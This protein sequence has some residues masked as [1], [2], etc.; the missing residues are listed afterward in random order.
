MNSRF[1]IVLPILFALMLAIGIFIGSKLN[2]SAPAVRFLHSEKKSSDKLNSVLNFIE[3]EYVDTVK[4]DVLVEKAIGDLLQNLDPHSV[5]MT[6]KDV[7][8]MREPMEG[9][10]EGIGIEFSIIKDTIRV[11]SAIPGGPSEALGIKAG[12]KIVKIEGKN[13]A[14]VKIK[15]KDV[16][17]K[18]RGKGGTKVTVSILRGHS[19]KLIDYT[20]TRG[21]IPIYSVDAGYMLNMVTGYIKVSRF[22]ETTHKEFLD[23]ASKLRAEGMKNMILDLRGNGGGLL[24]TAINIC[25]EFLEKGKVIVYTKGKSHPKETIKATDK[26]ILSDTKL[27]V[28]IDESSASASEI[29]AGAIQ[30]ND[31]GMIVGRR[32]FGKGLVQRESMFSDSSAIRLTVARYYT[33]TGRCIQKPYGKDIEDYYSEEYN[34]YQH[35]ELMHADSIHENDSLKYTTPKGKIVYGG[36]GITPDVFIPLD[37]AGRNS[38]LTELVVKGILNQFGFDYADK[39]RKSL[40]GMDMKKFRSTFIIDEKIM[41][42]FVAY[43]EKLGVKANPHEAEVSKA[44]IKNL[45]KA[46][47]AR[48]IWGNDGFYPILNEEDKMI[49]KAITLFGSALNP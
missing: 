42:E 29:V 10:F 48:Q 14:G 40:S 47:I 16:L 21:T 34:R 4:K 41:N 28:L 35:G 12:D 36:G 22:A 33:P 32:S 26:G 23:K 1:K 25:D 6:A 9:N 38:Y 49:L 37:T 30:D 11:V 17:G 5:Y 8:E 7:Q 43:S 44:L 45:I 46:S 20:I 15:N 31:R 3:E 27:I 18:L 19:K 24:S 2:F 39:N 13:A